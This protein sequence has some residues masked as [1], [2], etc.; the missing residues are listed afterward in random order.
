MSNKV[1]Q[2]EAVFQAVTNVCGEQEVYTPSK[3]E[4]AQINLVL[5]EGIKSGKIVCDKTY[6]DAELRTYVSGLQSNWLRKDKRLNGGM[7]YVA[8]NPGSRAGS[9]DPQIKAMRA[10]L[11]TQT[12]DAKRQEIQSFIDARLA[13][14]KPAKAAKVID[15]S[16]LPTE[17]AE[18]Y[19]STNE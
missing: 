6:T 1:G 14:I 4:R 9:S 2:K 19:S 3:E 17:L 10:L 11:S 7:Q 18:K 5:F 12:D 13:A 8:K 15:F 16:S